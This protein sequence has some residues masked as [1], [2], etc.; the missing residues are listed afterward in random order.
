MLTTCGLEQVGAACVDQGQALGLHGRVGNLPAEDMRVDRRWEGD[1]YVVMVAGRV[2]QCCAL[3]EWY[4]LA[5]EIQVRAGQSIIR[6]HDVVENPGYATLPLQLLYHMNIGFPIIDEGSRVLFPSC[7][8]Q[9]RDQASA[10][11]LAEWNRLSGPVK[12]FE[13]QVFQHDMRADAA[14][15]VTAAVI[16]DRLAGGRAVYVRYRPDELPVFSQW[17]MLGEGSYLMGMEPG[18]CGVEG[19][20]TARATGALRFIEPGE[21]REF[22]LEIGVLEGCEAIAALEAAIG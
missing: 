22:H 3:S 17:K 9:P 19:R 18:I 7:R 15:L 20:E 1:D 10:A 5:R 6:I 21:R 8:V 14:G 11:G 4:I 12:G 2:V 13:A 16:N